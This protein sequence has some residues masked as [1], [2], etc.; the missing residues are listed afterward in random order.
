MNNLFK[1]YKHNKDFLSLVHYKLA[2]KLYDIINHK[3]HP[4]IILSGVSKSGKTLLL[5]TL[6]NDIFNINNSLRSEVMYDNVHYEKSNIHFYFDLKLIH[7]D[8]KF[9]NQ[10]KKIING[11]NYYTDKCN[12]IVFDNYESVSDIV[13][14]KFRVLLEK[15]MKTSKIIIITQRYNRV[16]D[17]LKSRF[18]NIRVPLHKTYDKFLYFKKLLLKHLFIIDDNILM[19]IIKK[20]DNIDY[21]FI[22]ILGYFKTKQIHGDIYDEII[23]KYIY[24]I[25]SDKNI[26]KKITDIKQLLYLSKS[27]ID[28]NIFLRRLLSH[29]LNLNYDNEQ[30][31][32]I[33]KEFTEYDI[34]INKSF[35]DLLCLEGLLIGVIGV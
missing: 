19:N 30:K 16:I 22:N 9:I 10:L 15:S 2:Y 20:H 14:N 33:I 12:Y 27:V 24:I 29:L 25:K 28:V 8:E 32:K 5:K 23:E 35:R 31:M 4:N 3:N 7:N 17:P 1:D 34:M 6:L 18:L 11:Y 13:Q 21:N 26:C